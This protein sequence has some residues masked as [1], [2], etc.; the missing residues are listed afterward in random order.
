M[1]KSTTLRLKEAADLLGVHKS[2]LQRWLNDREYKVKH[3]PNSYR[4]KPGS[5]TSPWIVIRNEVETFIDQRA[6]VSV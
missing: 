1:G 4:V 2:T 3:F 5:K 6:N